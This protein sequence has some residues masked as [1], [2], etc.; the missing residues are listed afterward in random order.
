MLI[1]YEPRFARE[2]KYPEPHKYSLNSEHFAWLR[3]RRW[4]TGGGVD[5]KMS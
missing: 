2:I 5:C 3:R 1:G 4:T